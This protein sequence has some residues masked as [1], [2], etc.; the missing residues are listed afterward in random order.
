MYKKQTSRKKDYLK[1][2]GIEYFKN[3]IVVQQVRAVW[4]N[5]GGTCGLER[6]YRKAAA[7]PSRHPVRYSKN[8]KLA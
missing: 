6:Q 1:Q 4:R 7:A 3:L 5:G 8:H 2:Y